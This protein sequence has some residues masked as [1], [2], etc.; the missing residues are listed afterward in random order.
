M[1]VPQWWQ[2]GLY[3]FQKE[4]PR[5]PLSTN[6]DRLLCVNGQLPNGGLLG[7]VVVEAIILRVDVDAAD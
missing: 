6:Q 7:E 2:E 1:I 3:S 4:I 5:E